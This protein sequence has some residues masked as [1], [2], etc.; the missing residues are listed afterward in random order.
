ML[1]NAVNWFFSLKNIEAANNKIV[2]MTNKLLLANAYRNDVNKLHTGSDGRKVN[3]SVDSLLS[4][5]SFKYF[6]KE[7]GV[8]IYTFIDE[9]Q[10]LFH[11]TVISASERE[12]AY[13]I[14][15][16]LQN[17]V[18]KS[19]IHSTDTHGF[20]ETVFAAAHFIGTAFAPRIKNIGEQTIYSFESKQTYEKRGYMILPSRTIN[21]KLIQ[22]HWDDILRFMATIKLKYTTASQLFKRLSSYAKNHPLYQALKEFGRI[23][24]SIFILTYLDDVELR[25]QIEKQLNKGELSNKFSKAVFFANNQEFTEGIKEEQQMIAACTVLIQNAIVLWN[26]LYL[27][28]TLANNPDLV[29]QGR[30]VGSIKRGSVIAWGHINMQGEY[31]FTKSSTNDSQ[32]DM[33]KI[34]GLKIA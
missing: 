12:A 32:F 7:K 13:V 31:D 5:Y 2:A 3:V 24:K 19:S 22:N 14:D 8:T 23:I 4:S 16:L 11:V 9:R 6:G 15:G 10:L 18:L 27:S 26:Y 17:D 34:L 30:M 28:Q 21:L 20:T 33:D 29:E 1:T 25:Q